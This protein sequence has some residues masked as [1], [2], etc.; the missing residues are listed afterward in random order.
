MQDLN[1]IKNKIKMKNNEL[2]EVLCN[3]IRYNK[4]KY[5]YN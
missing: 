3:Y 1:F 4:H 2:S 5:T